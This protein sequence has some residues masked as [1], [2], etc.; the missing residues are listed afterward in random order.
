M[1][2]ILMLVCTAALMLSVTAAPA[3]AQP[4]PNA[5]CVAQYGHELGPVGQY[6]RH[7]RD[8][9]VGQRIV[10]LI[11]LHDDCANPPQG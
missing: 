3:A 1:K 8:P 10:K 7:A 2:R 11:A 5:S 4:N 6:Q 9:S